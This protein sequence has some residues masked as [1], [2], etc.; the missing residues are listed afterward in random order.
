MS[1][2]RLAQYKIQSLAKAVA[3]A[4]NVE[5]VVVDKN[6][7]RIIGTGG[8][9]NKIDDACAD[10]SLFAKVLKTEEPIINLNPED[11]CKKCSNQDNCFVFSN[12]IYP[13]KVEG[14]IVGIL[15]FAS[16]DKVQA[17]LIR[18]KKEEYFNMLK[19]T[20]ST[21]EQELIN[22]KITNKLKK[23]LIEVNEIINCL[24]KGIIIINSR[25]EVMYINSMALKIL[26]VNISYEKIIE[27]N[28]NEFIKNINFKVNENE[29]IVDIWTI[30][31][32]DIRVI[33]TIN[34]IA[35]KDHEAS[36]VISFD[37][38][39]DIINIAK[40]YENKEKIYFKDIIGNSKPM[41][42][43]IKKAKT[44]APYDSTVLL[45]GDS[46][47][48]KELFATSIHNEGSRKEGPFVAINCAG[49]PE[50]LIESELFGYEKGSFTGANSSGKKGL[51]ELA[52]NGTLFL[53]EIG[54]LPLYL[55]T[56]LLRVLQERK[57]DRVG[58]EKPININIRVIAATN[59]DLKTMIDNRE[60]RLDLYYRLNV[61]PIKLPSL[62]T[63]TGDIFLLSKHIISTISNKMNKAE[64][65]LSEEVK[66]LFSKYE[67]PGN[68]RELENVLEHGICFSTDEFIKIKDLPGY[69][70]DESES[71]YLNR[72]YLEGKSLEK[73]K[74]DF[75]KS[76]INKF[77]EEYGDTV[78]G[79]KEIAKKLDI[80]LTTLY[81]KISLDGDASCNKTEEK[82]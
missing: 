70:K 1:Y 25:N 60:F 4:L 44:V 71:R 69:M 29:E 68:I 13:I 54:D 21:I 28:I 43:A 64:V 39:S 14:E 15:A 79:K 66:E 82:V 18:V 12:M 74:T 41:L 2:L 22:I 75:E 33:Y 42:E 38:I 48:G 27:K 31:G 10:D 58:G 73:L 78:E 7:I 19:E 36:F 61:I 53:D 26:D 47:T 34:K 3:L 77:I 45:E 40:T 8:F 81:R 17:N 46:G 62:V 23:D 56:K 50:N 5:V 6:L 24:N 20:A 11:G 67:W 37:F 52:N 65:F 30:D 57:I 35:L 49:I 51:I 55:Q 32:K 63:R 76:V 72:D 16:C 9:Y 80:G 59:K